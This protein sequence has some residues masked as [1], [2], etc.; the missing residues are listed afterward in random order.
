MQRITVLF[1]AFL[2]YLETLAKLVVRAVWSPLVKR[3]ERFDPFDNVGLFLSPMRR[4]AES[5]GYRVTRTLVLG[6]VALMVSFLPA[7]A[8]P[9]WNYH[10][11]QFLHWNMLGSSGMV[12]ISAMGIAGAQAPQL[13][14]FRYGTVRR[15]I[16]IGTFTLTPGTQLPAVLIPQVGM[17]SRVLFDVEGSYTVATAPLV[18]ANTDG[19]D[20]I[21]ARAQIT[22]N[23]GSAQIV[24]CS[25]IGIAHINAN[26]NSALP[27]KRGGPVGVG[28][29]NGTQLPLAI[30]ASTFTYKGILPVNAN[31]RRQFEMGLLNLQAP[32]LRANV[33]L[34]FNPLT[35]LFTVAT[36]CTL[37]AATINLSYEYF[38]IPDLRAYAMPPLTLV[39]SIEEA[40]IAIAAVGQQIYQIPRLGTMIEYHA[41]PIF[42][43][44]YATGAVNATVT[45]FDIRYNKT[46]QQYQ[47]LEGDWETYEAELYGVGIDVGQA[48]TASAATPTS[49]WQMKTSAITFNL[50]A[51]GDVTIN[52]GDFRDAI[53]TEENTT[54]ESIIT[55][56]A[57]TV[58][59]AGADNLFHVRRVV[60]RIV[61]APA[62][63][64]T[65][66][67]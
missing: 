19:F 46:D 16:N 29:V 3:I 22:L 20:S 61:P 28:N 37:F 39:R 30:G 10:N 45:E 43:L 67:A 38:E 23:N 58:L 56:K 8:M 24:D 42:N 9:V 57:G 63:S 60:Q 54:T 12:G 17:I 13:I 64:S 47:V 52:G 36:N 44:L 34:S 2:M 32:E 66:A 4:F 15:R 55:I 53:D 41:I 59:H 40:P 7:N 65:R 33:L 5:G 11:H 48:P 14:P 18:V 50:W 35:S 49:R 6:M 31:Q 1:L 51:A 26:I 21:F 62:P 25:G 27:V